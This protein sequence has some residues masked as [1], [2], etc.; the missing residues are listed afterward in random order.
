MPL[1]SSL[2]PS[3]AV[4]LRLVT[5]LSV[6]ILLLAFAVVDDHARAQQAPREALEDTYEALTT[7]DEPVLPVVEGIFATFN[8]RTLEIFLGI[9]FIGRSGIALIFF[10]HV[11]LQR[12]SWINRSYHRSLVLELLVAVEEVAN[13]APQQRDYTSYNTELGC[14]RCYA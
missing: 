10:V 6:F 14:K 4:G 2:N 12:R 11:L 9:N 1:E 5:R 7:L 3:T 13:E 8:H